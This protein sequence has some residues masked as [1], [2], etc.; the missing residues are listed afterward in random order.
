M[1]ALLKS[2]SVE[3]EVF[4]EL[5]EKLDQV[6]EKNDELQSIAAK[7]YPR[8]FPNSICFLCCRIQNDVLGK[9]CIGFNISCCSSFA[10]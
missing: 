2:N 9:V 8:K 6:I 10:Q 7:K 1:Y 5:F 4:E 3:T